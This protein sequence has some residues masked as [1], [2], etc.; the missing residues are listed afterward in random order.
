[1]M[2]PGHHIRRWAS[3]VFSPQTMARVIEPM[4]ADLQLEYSCAQ[5]AGKP[6]RAR[7]IQFVGYA[8]CMRVV[9]LC[10]TQSACSVVREMSGD[11]S[12]AL[13]RMVGF[14]TLFAV[15]VTGFFAGHPILRF[16]LAQ[17]RD[18]SV[19]WSDNPV[20]RIWLLA[21]LLPQAI[22][23]AI[24]VALVLG[25]SVTIGSRQLSRRLA[26]AVLAFALLG[27][28]VTFGVMGWGA[29]LANHHFR[30]TL[31]GY[32]QHKGT[33][34]LTLGEIR[35]L[36]SRISESL[37][38]SSAPALSTIVARTDL[39]YHRGYAFPAASIVLVL[40]LLARPRNTNR[41]LLASQG[42]IACGIYYGLMVAGE[43]GMR[44]GWING[45]V[46]AWLPNIVFMTAATALALRR[47]RS[48]TPAAAIARPN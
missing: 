42:A 48:A 34:E 16:A 8:T 31:S 27:S 14:T 25:V 32:V 39:R 11:D 24:P 38:Q 3:R 19:T 30:T 43:A 44:S 28:M 36:R 46:G 37:P 9:V 23:L 33:A 15:L 22:T 5:A 21:L 6:W 13:R 10:G 35:S 41:V 26:A 40:F 47:F 7:W 29:P 17:S 45:A 2:R 12:R 4:L 1:M 18:V 20:E